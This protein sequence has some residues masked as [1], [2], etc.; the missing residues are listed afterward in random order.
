MG[1]E[2]GVMRQCANDDAMHE[3][4]MIIDSLGLMFQSINQ[5]AN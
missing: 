2:L 3:M 1:S 4:G 5:F